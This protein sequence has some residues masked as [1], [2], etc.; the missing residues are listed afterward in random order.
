MDGVVTFFDPKK[1][2]GFI[3]THGEDHY[4]QGSDV[5]GLNVLN[6][7]DQVSFTSKPNPRGKAPMATNIVLKPSQSASQR[8]SERAPR[9][10]D[11]PECTNCGRKIVPRMSFYQGAPDKSYCPFCGALHKKF[12]PCFIATAVYG[13]VNAPE[14]LALRRFRDQS[15][16]PYRAGRAFVIAYYKLSPP[17]ANFLKTRPTLA[18]PVRAALSAFVRWQNKTPAPRPASGVQKP[19][20][21]APRSGKE[22][23]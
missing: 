19:H 22:P 9:R 12:S 15:L 14:V 21:K 16:L 7:G 5:Q 6:S 23:Q 1:G 8:S 3:K 17:V 20:L 10:D 13:D 2:Y 11:R 4:F 18:K